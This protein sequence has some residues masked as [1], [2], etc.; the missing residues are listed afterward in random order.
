[1]FRALV[2]ALA[3]AGALA[4]MPKPVTADPLVDY[5]HAEDASFGWTLR[6]EGLLGSSTYAEIILQSQTWRGTPWRHHLTIFRPASLDPLGRHALLFIGG[7]RWHAGYEDPGGGPDLPRDA[8][9]MAMA[10]EVLGT[11]VALLRHVPPQPLFDGLYEDAAIAHSF[12]QYLRSGEPDWP[13]LLPMVK[14]AGAAMDAVHAYASEA[15]EIELDTFT[16]TGA[17]KRGW[18]SWLTA[19]VDSRVTALAP[20]VIDMLNLEAHVAHQQASWGELSWQLRDYTE[21]GLHELL[22]TEPGQRL[23]SVVDPWRHRA[24]IDQPKLLVMGTNDPYWPIDSANLYLHDLLGPT[25][26]LYVPNAGHRLRDYRR[27]VATLAALHRAAQG[28]PPLPGL[29]SAVTNTGGALDFRVE[30]TPPPRSVT[31]WTA[32]SATRDFRRARWEDRLCLPDGDGH[33]CEVALPESGF[34][35]V[36]AEALFDGPIAFPLTTPVHITGPTG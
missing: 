32:Q 7:G 24:R 33:L 21:R 14:S 35:A 8:Q 17:S 11:P 13:L 1:M 3:L 26:L 28:G 15:W 22:N 9:L 34:V 19:A 31:L 2:A 6:H 12:E 25:H 5:V 29:T 36:F 23:L 27:I 10:A 16:V 30:S 4:S 20:M 18:T